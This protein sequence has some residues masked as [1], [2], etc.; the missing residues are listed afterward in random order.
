MYFLVTF[1]ADQYTVT[2]TNVDK[3]FVSVDYH[4]YSNKGINDIYIIFVALYTITFAT[5]DK[6]FVLVDYHLFSHKGINDNNI[7]IV[8]QYTITFTTVDKKLCVN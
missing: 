5:V 4:L 3:N 1:P 7:T 2:F 8:D 6:N